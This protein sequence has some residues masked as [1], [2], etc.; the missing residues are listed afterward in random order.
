[1]KPAG[2]EE[3]RKYPM[4]TNIHGG[5]H[6]FYGNTFFH[7]MQVLAAKGYAV[8]FVNPRGSHS[9]SQTI[10]QGNTTGSTRTISVSQVAPTAGS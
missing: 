9:Y 5:P 2:Y 3:G 1:M 10:S 4:I 8:L 7:E 6:A